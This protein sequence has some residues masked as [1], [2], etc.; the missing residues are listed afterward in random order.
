LLDL[1]T[2]PACVPGPLA[3]RAIRSL[4]LLIQQR[5]CDGHAGGSSPTMASSCNSPP[6]TWAT[7][8]SPTAPVALLGERPGAGWVH[9]QPQGAQVQ[10]G[11]LP[12][13]DLMAG[14][15]LRPLGRPTARARLANVMSP[16]NCRA[17]AGSRQA[18]DLPGRPPR[19]WPAPTCRAGGQWPPT[20]RSWEGLAYRLHGSPLP[21]RGDG[22]LAQLH[23]G[24]SSGGQGGEATFARPNWGELRGLAAGPAGWHQRP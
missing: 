21:E 12:F 8:P 15:P 7:S 2:W 16:S 10:F 17:A 20:A 18:G 24:H 4:D 22:A 13:D 23:A 6:T 5:W 3:G 11:R 19:A 9:G 1:A 14:K